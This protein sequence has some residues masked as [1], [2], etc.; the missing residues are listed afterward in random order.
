MLLPLSLS[1]KLPQ[2]TGKE[3][4]RTEQELSITLLPILC[5]QGLLSESLLP[6]PNTLDTSLFTENM[7]RAV[8]YQKDEDI[9]LVS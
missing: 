1:L 8:V 6:T 9:L 3:A 7:T 5:E 4:A 2:E